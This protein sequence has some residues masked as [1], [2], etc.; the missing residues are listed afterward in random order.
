[1]AT[2]AALQT[3]ERDLRGIFGS[4]LQSLVIYGQRAHAGHGDEHH[5]HDRPP[6]PTL[7]VVESMTHDDL[8]T[9]AGRVAVWHDAGLATPLL[10]A[11][12]E[13]ERSLDAFPLEFGAILADHVVV[14]GTN[15]FASLAVN[16][17]DV[18]RACEVQARSHLLHLREEFLETRGRGDALSDLIVQ[19]APAFA[20]LVASIARLEGR[21]GDDP[22]A[23]AR[24]VERILEVPGAIAE[25]TKLAGVKEITSLEAER[26]FPPYLAAVE[27]LV[28]H[29]DGWGAR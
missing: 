28:S 19:S 6:T 27:R 23:A 13:F 25:V 26:L 17:A 11:A 29:V 22:E 2:P 12:R 16:A 4:R 14:S 15:P 10:L 3:L 18:R 21:S 8:R 7:A 20:A 5:G 9:A 24:H 1:M